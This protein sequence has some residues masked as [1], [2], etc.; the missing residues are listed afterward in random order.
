MK[1]FEGAIK[2]DFNN[3]VVCNTFENNDK[4]LKLEVRQV[5][6]GVYNVVE[7]LH[8]VKVD[9]RLYDSK[10]ALILKIERVLN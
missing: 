8:S 7:F 3:Y 1:K 6:K 5:R 2:L 10:E 4:G 9:S